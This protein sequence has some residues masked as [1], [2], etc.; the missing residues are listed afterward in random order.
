MPL[1]ELIQKKLL[2]PYPMDGMDDMVNF[3]WCLPVLNTQFFLK[4]G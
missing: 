4:T 1:T 3:K 2:H